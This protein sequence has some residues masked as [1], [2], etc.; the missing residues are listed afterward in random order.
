MNDDEF[1]DIDCDEDVVERILKNTPDEI[2]DFTLQFLLDNWYTNLDYEQAYHKLAA[3][4]Q[5]NSS[6]SLLA[7][8]T[9]SSD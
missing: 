8:S 1:A 2:D 4:C 6:S 9:S 7:T 3:K 5:Q